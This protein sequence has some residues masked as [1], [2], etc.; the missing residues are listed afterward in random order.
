MMSKYP[1]NTDLVS[2]CYGLLAVFFGVVLMCHY[3]GTPITA[4]ILLSVCIYKYVR[5]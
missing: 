5:V 3:L 2:L 1:D 4:L